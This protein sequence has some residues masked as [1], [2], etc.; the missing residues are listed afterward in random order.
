MDIRPFTQKLKGRK[1]E[2][3]TVTISLR[4][5]GSETN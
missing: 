3:I 5:E 1:K 4:L 2:K